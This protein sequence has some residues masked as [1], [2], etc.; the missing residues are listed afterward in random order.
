MLMPPVS[1]GHRRCGRELAEID[2][3]AGTGGPG[4]VLVGDAQRARGRGLIAGAR[5]P[6]GIG[7]RGRGRRRHVVGVLGALDR[8]RARDHRVDIGD[9]DV[10][11]PGR[12][13][14][15]VVAGDEDRRRDG[16]RWCDV[17]QRD[18]A[19]GRHRVRRRVGGHRDGIRLA[20]VGIRLFTQALSKVTALAGLAGSKKTLAATARRDKYR[21]PAALDHRSSSVRDSFA[22]SPDLPTPFRSTRSPYGCGRSDGRS[23]ANRIHRTAAFI[24]PRDSYTR[25]PAMSRTLPRQLE[26]PRIREP[27]GG[28][29]GQ[30]SAQ[31]KGSRTPPSS[32]AREATYRSPTLRCASSAAGPALRRRLII[33]PLYSRCS[34]E[35]MWCGSK[36]SR[37]SRGPRRCSRRRPCCRRAPAPAGARAGSGPPAARPS[38]SRGRATRS[39]S[40]RCGASSQATTDPEITG[41]V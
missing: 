31:R 30:F 15:G 10:V 28:C 18:R 14:A 35:V 40:G 21:R 29:Q 39:G 41:A 38:C 26:T 34:S 23:R 16:R 25:K 1:G 13:D 6:V 3:A 5:G 33:A 11:R 24:E 8:V 12:Q 2:S 4:L 27:L 20:C 9:G 22:L 36:A 7:D 37:C 32:S 19:A 17:A